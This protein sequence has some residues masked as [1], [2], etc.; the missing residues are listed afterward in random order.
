[1]EK[2]E[3]KNFSC[4]FFQLLIIKSPDPDSLNGFNESGST[5]LSET[6]HIFLNILKKCSELPGR[7][8]GHHA[9]SSGGGGRRQSTGS[10]TSQTYIQCCGAGMFIP[11]PGSDF[12]SSRIPDPNFFSFRTPDRHQKNGF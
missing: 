1:M 8:A 2:K 6:L 4:T 10:S 11:D 5:T 9:G 3:R 12:F 7:G